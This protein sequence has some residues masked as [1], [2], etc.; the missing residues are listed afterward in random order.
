MFAGALSKELQ[1]WVVLPNFKEKLQSMQEQSGNNLHKHC[2][3]IRFL[4]EAI[5]YVDYFFHGVIS[6]VE[7]T[8]QT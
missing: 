5:N 3:G 8:L 1:F 6:H 7:A 2:N 4:Q